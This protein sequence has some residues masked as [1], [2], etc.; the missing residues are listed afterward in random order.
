M[1]KRRRRHS[2]Y[3]FTEKTHSKRGMV[4][5]GLAAAL[6]VLYIVFIHFAFRADGKLS[7]YYGSAGVMAMLVS[8]ITL[9]IAA[10]SLREEDSFKLFPRLGLGLAIISMGC[11]IGT[12]AMGVY[13]L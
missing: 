11:W 3:K 5:T 7:M 4:A 9:V 6:L 12:Y 10:G 1:R 8:V 2:S 13:I